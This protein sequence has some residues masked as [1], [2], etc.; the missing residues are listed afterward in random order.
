MRKE[1][2]NSK[3]MVY[4]FARLQVEFDLLPDSSLI[5]SWVELFV[6][7][8]KM[9]CFSLTSLKLSVS[10]GGKRLNKS[11]DILHNFLF[12]RYRY[13]GTSSL[14]PYWLKI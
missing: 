13:G 2:D 11:T 1:V 5:V 3:F 8:R 7:A 14:Q 4:L 6:N 12:Q 9:L 10:C